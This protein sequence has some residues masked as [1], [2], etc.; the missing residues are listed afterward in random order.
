MWSRAYLHS[1]VMSG[2]TTGIGG[3]KRRFAGTQRSSAHIVFARIHMVEVFVHSPSS[4][5]QRVS[6]LVF[7]HVIGVMLSEKMISRQQCGRR[8][9]VRPLNDYAGRGSTHNTRMEVS[10]GP[11]CSLTLL[12]S[13]HTSQRLSTGW[14]GGSY[15]GKCACAQRPGSPVICFN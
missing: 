15:Q 14:L 11:H 7:N 6:S 1:G 4:H 10:P 12:K 2:A 3:V 9:I 13:S 5:H 8:I